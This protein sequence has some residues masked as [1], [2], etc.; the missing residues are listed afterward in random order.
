[1]KYMKVRKQIFMKLIFSTGV[2]LLASLVCAQDRPP[3]KPDVHFVPTPP[4]I[5]EVMLRLAGK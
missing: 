4:E 3:K 5:V 1:M 2:I